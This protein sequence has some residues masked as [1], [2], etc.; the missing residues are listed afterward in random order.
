MA[1][2]FAIDRDTHPGVVHIHA[3]QDA[4]HSELLGEP[5]WAEST[6]VGGVDPLNLLG[7][8]SVG[9]HAAPQYFIGPVSL[10]KPALRF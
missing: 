7:N 10:R 2:C 6:P 8:A 5:L 4:G 3:R 1:G 9:K